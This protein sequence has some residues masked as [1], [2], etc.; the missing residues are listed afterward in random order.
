[1]TTPRPLTGLRD[2]LVSGLGGAIAIGLVAWLTDTHHPMLMASFGASCFLM[3]VVPENPVSQPRNVI[4]GHLVSA[5]VGMVLLMLAGDAWWA[6][7]LGVGMAIIAMRLTHT[8]HPPA[9]SDPLLMMLNLHGPPGWDF[10]LTPVLAGA[11]LVVVVAVF[12]NRLRPGLRY[13]ERW[14]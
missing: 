1:M 8:N 4:L 13:P 9:A 3:F 2:I 7:G 6:M 10:L 5:A 12:V 14:F 11:T